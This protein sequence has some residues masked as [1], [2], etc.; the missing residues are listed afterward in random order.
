MAPMTERGTIEAIIPAVSA[1]R[2]EEPVMP[3]VEEEA[4]KKVVRRK[5]ATDDLGDLD[6]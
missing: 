4:P 1:Y 3:V 6:L 2:A 5:K